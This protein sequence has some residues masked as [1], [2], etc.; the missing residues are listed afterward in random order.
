MHFIPPTI[1]APNSAAERKV[2]SLFK[3][4]SYDD[5][6][7]LLHSVNLPYHKYKQWAEIDFL[8]ISRKG[9]LVFEVKGGEVYRYDGIWYGKD[10]WGNEHRKSEGPND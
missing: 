2:F 8:L 5:R 10:R 6:T 1:Y 3:E 9:V 4:L 7:Y